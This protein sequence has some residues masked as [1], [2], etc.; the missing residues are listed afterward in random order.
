MAC[1]PPTRASATTCDTDAS[2]VLGMVDGFKKLIELDDSPYNGLNFCLGCFSE[3][4]AKPDEEIFDV[5]RYF[6]SRD[7][8]F[9]VHFYQCQVNHPQKCRS[10]PPGSRASIRETAELHHSQKRHLGLL[11]LGEDTTIHYRSS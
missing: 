5:I 1:T 11:Q 9:N 7:K 4:L 3:A 2:P 8:I 6:G 10:I